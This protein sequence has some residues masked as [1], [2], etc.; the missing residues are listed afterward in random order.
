MP[1]NGRHPSFFINWQ[2]SHGLPHPNLF[3]PCRD[4]LAHEQGPVPSTLPAMASKGI[5][6][7]ARSLMFQRS[8]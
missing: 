5:K 1:L 4:P 7:R 3:F 2:S 8:P 6:G